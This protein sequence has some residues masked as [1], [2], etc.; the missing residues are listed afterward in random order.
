[1]DPVG[2]LRQT[3]LFADLA[4]EEVAAL[5]PEVGERTFARGEAVWIEGDPALA[6]YVVVDGQLK[7]HRVGVDGGEVILGINQAVDLFGEVGLFHPGGVRLVSM[8]AMTPSRCLRLAKAPLIAFLAGHPV[9]MERMLQRLSVIAGHAAHSFSALAFDDIQR[10][11]AVALVGLADEFGEDLGERGTRIR[12]KL[13][14]S[15]LAALV[16]A[17]RENVN[18]ALAGFRAAGWISQHDGHFH[19]HD[20][21]SLR[22]AV[23]ASL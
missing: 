6:L 11:V 12:L 13:S 15:T 3:Y 4:E 7:A 8:T 1:M 16:A 23:D 21:D 20:L 18:R 17:S 10:R 2:I 9:A 19:L 5:L 22:R 14:Q